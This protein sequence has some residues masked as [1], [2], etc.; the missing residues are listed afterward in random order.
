MDFQRDEL[1]GVLQPD[2]LVEQQVVDR[3]HAER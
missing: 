2:C 3:R 1:V